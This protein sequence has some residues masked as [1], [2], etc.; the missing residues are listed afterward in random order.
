[1]GRW[2]EKYSRVKIYLNMKKSFYTLAQNSKCGKINKIA[3][4]NC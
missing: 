4:V 1:M 3:I 2:M